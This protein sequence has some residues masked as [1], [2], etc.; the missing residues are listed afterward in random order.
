MTEKQVRWSHIYDPLIIEDAEA[1][2]GTD[3]IFDCTKLG[4][5][6]GDYHWWAYSKNA[7]G[8]WECSAEQFFTFVYNPFTNELEIID[9]HS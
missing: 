9:V 5:T 3:F 6:R 2:S 4:V 1:T 8:D 7:C